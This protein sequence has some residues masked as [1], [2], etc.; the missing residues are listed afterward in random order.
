VA[1]RSSSEVGKPIQISR[2]RLS[3][4]VARQYSLRVILAR[5]RT[6]Y[7]GNIGPSDYLF[8]TAFV[9]ILAPQRVIEIGTLTGFSAGIIAAALARRHGSGASWVDTID[10]NVECII[11]RTRLSG[12]EIAETFPELA[13][14]VRLHVPTMRLS[15][16]NLKRDELE[17]AFMDAD[18]RHPAALDLLWVAPCVRRSWIVLHDIQLGTITLKQ[19]KWVTTSAGKRFTARNGFR[20]LASPQISGRKYWGRPAAA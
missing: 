1:T 19:S 8:L 5:R 15:F 3:A 4:N 14:L 18:H 9:S 13:P 12:F 17:V 7:P 2:L 11:D 6:S 10:I 20:L 16:P